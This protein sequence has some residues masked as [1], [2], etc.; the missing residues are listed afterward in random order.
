M[1][2]NQLLKLILKMFFLLYSL[3][4]IDLGITS[5]ANLKSNL[6]FFEPIFAMVSRQKLFIRNESD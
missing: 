4:Y 3:Y 1:L 5:I 2:L 6:V